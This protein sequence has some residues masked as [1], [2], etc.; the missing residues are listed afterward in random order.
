MNRD[1]ALNRPEAEPPALFRCGGVA[2]VYPHERPAGTWIAASEYGVSFAVLNWDR[3]KPGAKG[4]SR[5][6]VIPAVISCPSLADAQSAL[7]A[8]ELGGAWPFRLFGFFGPKR[9]VCEWRWD[10]AKLAAQSHPWKHKH[11][12]SS[13]LSDKEA[14]RRRQPLC[15]SAL[16]LPGCGTLAWLRRVHCVHGEAPGPFSICVHRPDAATLSYTLG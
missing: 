13:G 3:P 15:D 14:A 11:W 8:R 7:A 16:R 1:D 10:G 12:F 2:A 6:G 4:Q 5:G 9:L